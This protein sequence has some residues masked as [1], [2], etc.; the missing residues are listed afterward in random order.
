VTMGASSINQSY[1][2]RAAILTAER[3]G[4][5][6]VAD[7]VISQWEELAGNSA[8]AE[9]ELSSAHLPNLRQPGRPKLHSPV[10]AASKHRPKGV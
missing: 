7:L 2:R 9:L 4:N 1:R 8:H 6:V 3:A 10:G 5:R